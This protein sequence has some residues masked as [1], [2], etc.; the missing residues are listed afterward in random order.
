[1]RNKAESSPSLP[2]QVL[3]RSGEAFFE[4]A[5]IVLHLGPNTASNFYA[6]LD[7]NQILGVF[8]A[9]YQVLEIGSPVVVKIHLSKG[10]WLRVLTAVEWVRGAGLDGVGRPGLGLRFEPLT[11]QQHNAV[12]TYTCTREPLVFEA[13]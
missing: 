12:T 1:M 4:E 5:E 10:G 8:V 7:P 2:A 13:S 9:T 6:G 3:R 11:E